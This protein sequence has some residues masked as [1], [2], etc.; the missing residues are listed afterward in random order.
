MVRNTVF[1]KFAT[2][3]EFS[4]ASIR[5]PISC[6]FQAGFPGFPIP[7]PDED[8]DDD[9]TLERIGGDDHEYDNYEASHDDENSEASFLKLYFKL[10]NLF[11][12]FFF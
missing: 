5:I 9:V 7:G 10:L 12:F 8:D 4:A 6:R 2:G 11:L 1:V 3:T